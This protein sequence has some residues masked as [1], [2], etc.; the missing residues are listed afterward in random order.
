MTK[1]P[2]QECNETVDIPDNAE[3]GFIKPCDTHNC[4]AQLLVENNRKGSSI[5]S[6]GEVKGDEL[7]TYYELT[8]QAGEN[9]RECDKCGKELTVG[10]KAYS[11]HEVPR[12]VTVFCESCKKIKTMDEGLEVDGKR[13]EVQRF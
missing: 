2:C 11:Q 7:G 13:E 9:L 6:F 12:Q 1:T 10:D 8:F 5:I 4:T 3:E